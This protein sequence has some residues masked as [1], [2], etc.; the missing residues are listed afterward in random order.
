MSSRKSTYD[1]FLCTA[2]FAM[3]LFWAGSEF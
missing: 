2:G 1:F 3:Q